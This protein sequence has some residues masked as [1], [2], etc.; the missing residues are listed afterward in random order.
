MSCWREIS[1]LRT[2]IKDK[3]KIRVGRHRRRPWLRPALSVTGAHPTRK[4]LF[5]RE[6]APLSGSGQPWL[7]HHYL[8]PR[9]WPGTYLWREEPPGLLALQRFADL[10]VIPLEATEEAD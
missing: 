1:L 4:R 7:D 6:G 5:V 8:G 9:S 3:G 10:P 2:A